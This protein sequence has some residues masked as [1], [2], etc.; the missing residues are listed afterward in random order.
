MTEPDD[1]DAVAS[2]TPWP[3]I[4]AALGLAAILLG[5]LAIYLYQDN[6]APANDSADV[7]FARDMSIHHQQAVEMANIAYR[8]TQ[9]PEIERIALDIATTQQFQIGMMTGW[10]DIWGRSVSSDQP[11]MSWMGDYDMSLPSPPP[12]LEADDS[13]AGMDMDHSATPATGDT[14]GD[15]AETPL[16]P[17]MATQSQVDELNT[18]PPDQM[19]IRFLQL[20]IRHHQGGVMMAQ[21]A[22]EKAKDENV[23]N[24]AQ[25]V[26][27]TQDAE[28]ET[29]TQMLNERLA[30]GGSATSDSDA[31]GTPVAGTPEADMSGMPEKA[32]PTATHAD[33]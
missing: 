11:L 12:G 7:G 22:L 18:L 8:R 28:I 13:M 9:D 14:A 17:G 3:I 29:M 33:H 24:F 2:R 4:A 10:L 19:D 23:L 16:M 27:N 30:A 25:Q 21:A 26:I 6:K 32:S 15:A 20:M 5:A 31:S 1:T